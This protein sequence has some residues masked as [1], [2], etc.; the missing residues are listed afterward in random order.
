MKTN[1]LTEKLSI[2]QK[3]SEIKTS[4]LQKIQRKNNSLELENGKLKQQLINEQSKV[5]M[6]KRTL[7]AV[8]HCVRI[9]IL[10]L[11]LILI[12]YEIKLSPIELI[13]QLYLVPA[14]TKE[15]ATFPVNRTKLEFQSSM[16][17]PTT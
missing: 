8:Y 2:E 7:T 6:L 1:D 5:E 9:H 3:N 11:V 14:V 12:C 13:T 4:T 16:M 17:L 10:F 15:T